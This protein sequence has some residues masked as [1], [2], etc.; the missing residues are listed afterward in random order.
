MPCSGVPVYCS[1]MKVGRSRALYDVSTAA[2]VLL[3]REYHAVV[4]CCLLFVPQPPSHIP[5]YNSGRQNVIAAADDAA[6]LLYRDIA[7]WHKMSTSLS[8]CTAA[9]CYCC[10]C[11]YCCCRPNRSQPPSHTSTHYC[12]RQQRDTTPTY[13]V[14]FLMRDRARMNDAAGCGRLLLRSLFWAGFDSYCPYLRS[15]MG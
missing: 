7:T 5:M 6:V 13:V 4:D 2:A 15:G 8:C 10:C 12:G 9:S 11:C 14:N 1:I 3:Y